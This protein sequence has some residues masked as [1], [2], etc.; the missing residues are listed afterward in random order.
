MIDLRETHF[1]KSK[2]IFSQIKTYPTLITNLDFLLPTFTFALS[3][4]IFG[5]FFIGG[6]YVAVKVFNLSPTVMGICLSFPALGYVL[7]NILVSKIANRVSTKNLMV[8]G[9][10]ILFLG[11]CISLLLSNFYFARFYINLYLYFSHH[12]YFHSQHRPFSY[13]HHTH[14][15]K[16]I[17]Y[18]S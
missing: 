10:V 5:I 14:P 13:T 7:G 17:D 1:Q 2:D 18:I 16:S 4:S 12:G 11:P 6:P 8:L 3:F 9:S 15:T